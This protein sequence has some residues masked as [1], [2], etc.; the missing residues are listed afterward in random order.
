MRA[1]VNR[2]SEVVGVILGLML[3]VLALNLLLHLS[4]K[5]M[6]D[7]L[8]YRLAGNGFEKDIEQRIEAA[9][10]D[11]HDGV[12]QADRPLCALLGL[13]GLREASDLKTMSSTGPVRCR[14]LGLSGA[15]GAINTIADQS[16]ELLTG[17]LR[18]DVAVIGLSPFLLVKP[19]AS[20]APPADTA[21]A[22]DAR[23]STPH[24]SIAGLRQTLKA[25]RDWLWFVERRQDVNGEAESALQSGKQTLLKLFKAGKTAVRNPLTDPWREMIR[26]DLPEHPSAAALREGMAAYEARQLFEADS[27]AP[28]R[29]AEQRQALNQFVR[30][31][32]ARGA[33][34]VIALMPEYSLFR[35]RLPKQGADALRAGLQEAFGAEAPLIIDLRDAVP[36]SGFTNLAHVNQEGRAIVSQRLGGNIAKILQ[37][38]QVPLMRSAAVQP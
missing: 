23:Q 22:Q 27:Y 36:D 16:R 31:L 7:W 34:V 29:I 10:A 28:D 18:P 19:L 24:I 8:P 26:L 21:T 6:P 32:R 20:Q 30:E 17:S 2:L 33:R 38:K 37:P 4:D 5:V 9:Q 15:G 1:S 35:D 14:Y 3:T 13:S 11:Y 25:A 12:V